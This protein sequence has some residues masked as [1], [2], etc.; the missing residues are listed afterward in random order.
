MTKP[1]QFFQIDPVLK[2]VMRKH[3]LPLEDFVERDESI[4]LPCA[5]QDRRAA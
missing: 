5:G 3:G 2:E 4:C 1:G